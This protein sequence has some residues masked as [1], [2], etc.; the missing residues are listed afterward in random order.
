M[1]KK[2]IPVNAQIA[3]N[4]LQRLVELKLRKESGAAISSSEWSSNFAMMIPDTFD[5]PD[6]RRAKL[7]NWDDVIKLYS[8]P[9]G[10]GWD[11]YQPLFDKT[12]Q[13]KKKRET[14]PG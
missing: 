4:K 14:F 10:M 2:N 13:E 3:L 12:W 8:M 5:D 9:G 11:E 6:L 1:Q 7:S